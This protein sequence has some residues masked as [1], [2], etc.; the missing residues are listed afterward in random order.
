M[1]NIPRADLI[2]QRDE[3]FMRKALEQAQM[4]ADR[5]EVPVGAVVVYADD[6]V[7]SAWNQPISGCDPTAHAEVIALRAAAKAIGNY[8]LVDCQLYVTLEPC[9]MCAGAIVHSRIE[10]LVFGAKE[11]KAGV[12]S[13][14]LSLLQADFLNHKISVQGA[15]LERECGRLISEF[16]QM[17]RAQKRALKQ[18]NA[19]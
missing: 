13:S 2:A 14:N 1:N 16:F 3:R 4:A 15:V 8:R 17:R 19:D 12:V 10:R 7:A 9:M 18:N 11:P 5:G 6:V